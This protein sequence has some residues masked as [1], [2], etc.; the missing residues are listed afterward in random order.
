MKKLLS[1]FTVTATLIGITSCSKSEI[2]DT[3]VDTDQPVEIRVAG[4][5]LSITPSTRAPHTGTSANGL[6]ARVLA[7]NESKVYT[8]AD[9]VTNGTITF[10][11]ASTGN[12]TGY[13]PAVH[14]PHPTNSV[15]LLGLYPTLPAADWTIAADGKSANFTFDG[16]HDV[17][18]TQ[19]VSTARTDAIGD[20]YKTLTFHHLLTKL[21]LFIIAKNQ[22][23][24]DAW[25]TVTSIKVKST[26]ET[27]VT[28]SDASATT[29]PTA[30]F[31]GDTNLPFYLV[32]DNSAFQSKSV[33]LTT[34]VGTV[35]EYYALV[36]SI[37]GTAA[38]YKLIVTTSK[39]TDDL[40]VPVSL[41]VSPG[42]P[43]NGNTQ[44]KQFKITLTFTATDIEAYAT[45]VD[46]IPGGTGSGTVQ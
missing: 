7:S 3:V 14:Y 28:F 43:Y 24:I 17:M 29:A 5:A 35:P 36:G 37:N 30:G 21:D 46:W 12:P 16:S 1:I 42:T 23:A 31:I 34:T 22:A 32:S 2:P 44:G 40:E 15:Y 33:T 8:G 45:V 19:E 11:D 38:S 41:E 13:N 25:G 26:N 39:H 20:T 10:Q 9:L 6:T 27:T 18:A 4:K